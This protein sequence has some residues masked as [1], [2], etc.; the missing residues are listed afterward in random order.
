MAEQKRV[1][2]VDD[3][4]D[5]VAIVQSKLERLNCLVDVAY[6]GVEGW[7]R[8]RENTPDLIVLDVMMP[9]KDGFQMC[10]ELKQDEKHA[11]IPVVM[12]TAVADHI[13]DT[14]YTQ[15]DA[16]SMEAED[17][18]PKGP[19]CTNQVINSIKGLLDL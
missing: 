3:D 9:V 11:D 16:M 2:V 8:V 14:G 12:L 10:K 7:E 15:Y 17:Y 1:L 6:N 18:I 5:F 4:P 19:D 13:A